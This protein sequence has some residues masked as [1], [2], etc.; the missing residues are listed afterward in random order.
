[1]PLSKTLKGPLRLVE[2]VLWGDASRRPMVSYAQNGEDVLLRRALGSLSNG[3]YIDV[4]ANDPVAHSVT[5]HFYDR[6]WSGINIEPGRVFARLARA[7]PR[8]VNLQVALSNHRGESTF[9]EYPEA[10][11]RSTLSEEVAASVS[12][13]RLERKVPLWTLAEVCRQYVERTIDFLKIDVE[14]HEHEVIA[15]GDWKR[16][17][18]RV[19]LVE[20][21]LTADAEFLRR[22]WEPLLLEA[23]YR[24]AAFDGIN[25]YYVRG[26]DAQFL[27]HFHLP[28]CVLD[29]F[30][31]HHHVRKY[32]GLGPLAVW[33]ARRLQGLINLAAFW[34]PRRPARRSL[35]R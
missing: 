14:R 32:E 31:P 12:F 4:G 29:N 3:F 13:A 6:G 34:H 33:A 10:H 21:P 23:D 18:P 16:W 8:D 5:K 15:G 17:R 22:L 1:M 11:G 9:Y 28:L 27:P 24:F 30:V 25:R 19:V 7:R 35:P 20:S 2:R 26:E